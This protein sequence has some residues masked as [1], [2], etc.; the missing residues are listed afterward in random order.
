MVGDHF[1]LRYRQMPLEN[2]GIFKYTKNAMYTYGFVILWA[3]ALFNLSL[4]ALIAAGFQHLYIWVH[5]YC[6]EKPDMDIIY[7][8]PTS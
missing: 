4:P 5:F 2:R 3:I 8:N 7:N 1:R 6:T